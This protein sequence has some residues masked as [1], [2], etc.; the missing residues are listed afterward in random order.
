MIGK[1]K[2]MQR[3]RDGREWIISF[4]TPVDFREKFDSLYGKDLTIEIKR[5][6]KKRSLDS[7][8]YAWVLI[9]KI[10]E[11]LQRREP[12]SGW[13]PK[14]VYQE[15]IRNIPTACSIHTVPLED[16]EEIIKDWESLGDGFQVELFPYSEGDTISGFFW[17]GSHLFSSSQMSALIS[18]LICEAEDL[19]IPTISDEEAKKMIGDW[20]VKRKEI[21]NAESSSERKGPDV[22]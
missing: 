14:Q 22:P 11:E 5:Y 9:N 10:T 13:T 1:L 3:S 21:V 6:S 17:K 18:R 2:D 16:A 15:A 7:N 12:R 20:A 4:T 8:A 19:G